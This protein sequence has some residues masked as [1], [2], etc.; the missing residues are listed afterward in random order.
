MIWFRNMVEVGSLQTWTWR[1]DSLMC[2][3]DSMVMPSI[4]NKKLGLSGGMGEIWKAHSLLAHMLR[5]WRSRASLAVRSWIR[6]VRGG[7]CGSVVLVSLG[8]GN[9]YTL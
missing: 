4:V 1:T 5:L 9:R 8:F 3:V 6:K 7:F 2:M